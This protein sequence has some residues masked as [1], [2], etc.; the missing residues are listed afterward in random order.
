MEHW[1]I[2]HRLDETNFRLSFS[3]S[4]IFLSTAILYGQ[5]VFKCR[6]QVETSRGV[7]SGKRLINH[8]RW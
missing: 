2:V 3:K 1:E 6:I 7:C 4:Y 8:V 5:D